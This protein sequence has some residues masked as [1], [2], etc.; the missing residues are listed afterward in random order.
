MLNHLGADIRVVVE[1]DDDRR[2][3]ADDGTDAAQQFAL[4]VFKFFGDHS[5]VQVEID[6]V[7]R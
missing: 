7:D 3:L 4:T 6:G 1:A 2:I 5:A